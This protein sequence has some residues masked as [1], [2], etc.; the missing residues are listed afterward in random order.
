[1]LHVLGEV[2]PLAVGIIVSPMPI[3]GVIALLLGPKGR[4][5][6]I[7]F[8]VA[9]LVATFGVT[10]AFASGSKGTTTSDSFFAQVF[11]IVL[12]FAFAALFLFLA[13][14]SFRGRPKKGEEPKEPKW[15]AA[16]DSFGVA[17]SAGLGVLL[18]VVNVKNIPVAIAAGSIIGSR[19]LAWPLVFVASAVFVLISCAGLILVTAIG[20]S[21]SATVQNGLHSAKAG[22]IRHNA[23]IMTVLFVILG[24]LQLGR[25]FEAF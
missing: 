8:T 10:L 5:N 17:K 7:V 11:H 23:I 19:D 14:R 25:A 6:A 20:G 1:M 21:S 16:I 9:F 22:L 18:G 15:L 12:G 24:A 13:Y 3:A 2:L 4:G